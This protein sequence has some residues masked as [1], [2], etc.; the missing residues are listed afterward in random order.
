[1]PV[2]RRLVAS[3]CSESSENALR[4]WWGLAEISATGICTGPGTAAGLGGAA[5]IGATGGAMGGGAVGGAGRGTSISA[6]KAPVISVL[7]PRPNRG[8]SFAAFDI[9]P[10]CSPQAMFHVE[11]G[12]AYRL[13]GLKQ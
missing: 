13:A 1:M 11:Q 6:G 10:P 12:P 9:V 5:V 8:R 7:N 4:G 3:W 2:E